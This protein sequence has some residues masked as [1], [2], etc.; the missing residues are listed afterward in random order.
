MSVS[1][2]KFS[3]NISKAKYSKWTHKFR[4]ASCMQKTSLGDAKKRKLHMEMDTS[5]QS[6][7][8]FWY[9]LNMCLAVVTDV[10]DMEF[11]V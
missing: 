11:T 3:K 2:A 5:R 1:K 4:L 10:L 6:N 7:L 8:V 9:F